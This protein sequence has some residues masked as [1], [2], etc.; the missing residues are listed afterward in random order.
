MNTTVTNSE[1]S[2]AGTVI[3]EI[4]LIFVCI[5]AIIGNTCMWIIIYRTRKLRTIS[6]AFILCLNSADWLVSVLNMPTTVVALALG[7]WPLSSQACQ[8]FGFFNMF[9]LVQSVLSL[10]NISINRYVIVCKP[11]RFP[12]IYTTKRS[13]M[14]IIV[15]TSISIII[16]TPPL[17]GWAEYGYVDTQF[18]CFCLWPKSP[19][20]AFFM[21]GVCFGIPLAVMAICNVLIFKAVQA[22]KKRT[23][24]SSRSSMAISKNISIQESSSDTEV[25]T[26]TEKE[27]KDKPKIENKKERKH[28]DMVDV[29]VEMSDSNTETNDVKKRLSKL[30]SNKVKAEDVRLALALAICVVCF[31]I[32][33]FPFC[34]SML[35]GIYAPNSVS[36]DFHLATLLIGYSNSCMN[37][38]I[39]GIINKRIGKGFKDLFCRCRCCKEEKL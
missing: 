1:R 16:S 38:V 24:R 17:F 34:I 23:A 13:I 26:K 11:F 14:M 39:Y 28:V 18:Y 2:V 3:A 25:P 6:N 5:S 15:C 12:S 22:S 7:R 33:W 9:T 37:P 31:F 10:C 4:F 27:K 30:P 21:I 36:N 19:S 8:V 20:Y 29:Q 35:I 32:S